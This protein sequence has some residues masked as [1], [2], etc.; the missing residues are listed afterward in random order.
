MVVQETNDAS[1]RRRRATRS[2]DGQ[3]LADE[4]NRVLRPEGSNVGE[5]AAGS[6]VETLVRAVEVLEVLS[7]GRVLVLGACSIVGEASTGEA[8]S[9]FRE[10]G[11]SSD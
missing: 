7:D 8:D 3:K 2:I 11:R 10:A 4:E 9:L 5:P 6:V 1:E